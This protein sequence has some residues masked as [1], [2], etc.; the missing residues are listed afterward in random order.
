MKAKPWIL[1]LVLFLFLFFAF[2]YIGNQL[3]IE[4]T[5]LAKLLYFLVSSIIGVTLWRFWEDINVDG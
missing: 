1:E 4:G 2:L 5:F 3:K